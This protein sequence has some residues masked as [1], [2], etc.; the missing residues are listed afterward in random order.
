MRGEPDFPE[1]GGSFNLLFI[2]EEETT[3]LPFCWKGKELSV[4][5]DPRVGEENPHLIA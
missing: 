3:V 1:G 2:K 4:R 5:A